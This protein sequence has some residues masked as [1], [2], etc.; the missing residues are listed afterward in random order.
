MRMG[1]RGSTRALINPWGVRICGRVARAGQT[2]EA[3]PFVPVWS[4]EDR[5]V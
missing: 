2:R 1:G 3:W 5:E 4:G